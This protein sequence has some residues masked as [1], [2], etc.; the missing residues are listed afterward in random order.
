MSSTSLAIWAPN[1]LDTRTHFS[2]PM[3]HTNHSSPV[4]SVTGAYSLLTVVDT[5]DRSPVWRTL[6]PYGAGHG[7]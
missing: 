1:T 4:S 7:W 5:G 6:V 3:G 2:P